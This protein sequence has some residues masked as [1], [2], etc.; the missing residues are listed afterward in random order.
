MNNTYFDKDGRPAS[1]RSFFPELEILTLP[2]MFMLE[3]ATLA[4][5]DRR[6]SS[7][8]HNYNTRREQIPVAA[9]RTKLFEQMDLYIGSKLL[10]H[11]PEEIRNIENPTKFKH[12]FKKILTKKAYYTIDEFLVD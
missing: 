3:C 4:K 2:S 7:Y 9:H 11:V 6:T 10:N 1:C 12:E 5:K 8:D